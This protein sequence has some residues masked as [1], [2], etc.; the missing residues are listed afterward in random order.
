MADST[1]SL[2]KNPENHAMNLMEL[3]PQER[4]PEYINQLTVDYS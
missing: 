1:L 4:A 2:Q 3:L